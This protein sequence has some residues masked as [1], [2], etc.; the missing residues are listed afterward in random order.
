MDPK[1]S[2]STTRS[3]PVSMGVAQAEREA[4]PTPAAPGSNAAASSAQC[5]NSGAD[6][7]VLSRGV[8]VWEAEWFGPER[9]TII[10]LFGVAKLP[11]PHSLTCPA[12]EVRAAIAQK[13][14]GHQVTVAA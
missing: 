7:I 12:E 10:D 5:N 8:Q 9:R 2:G 14:P 1:S 4:L 11:T 13:N 6:R 3:Y